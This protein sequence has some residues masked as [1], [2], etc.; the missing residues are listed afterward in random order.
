[1]WRQDATLG[2]KQH[3]HISFT[4]RAEKDG[5]PFNLPIFDTAPPLT[6]AKKAPAKKVPKKK[7]PTA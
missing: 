2:H 5:R 6:P 7:T 3:I 4:D 1:V